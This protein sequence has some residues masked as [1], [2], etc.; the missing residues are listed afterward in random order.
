[1]RPELRPPWLL[2]DFGKDLRL[3]GWPVVGAA[4]GPARRV[5][6]LQVRNA[7]LP[8]DRDPTVYFTERA[9]AAGVSF[10]AG[11]M[12]AADLRGFAVAQ[13]A[14]GVSVV[15]TG[16]LGNAESVLSAASEPRNAAKVGTINVVAVIDRSLTLA[17]QI[18]ALSIV[19][20]ARTAAVMSFGLTMMGDER[21]V[22]GTGTDCI[23]VAAPGDKAGLAHCGLHTS[24]GRALAEAAY[25]SV[26]NTCA[27]CLR[28][29][30]LR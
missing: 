11:L 12:T 18:E 1:M 9:Q 29:P 23:L 8:P 5:A 24:I 26:R 15:A 30:S 19:A 10:D 3:I 20:E 16:G 27:S 2:L 4:L 7:D 21:P 14:G 13:R 22:T 28:A 6:W 17:A 25:E